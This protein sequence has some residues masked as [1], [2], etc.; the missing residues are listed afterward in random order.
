MKEITEAKEDVLILK[1]PNENND[2]NK[3]DNQI[4][5][6]YKFLIILSFQF[7]LIMNCISLYW[8]YQ[9]HYFFGFYF[10]INSNT[11]FPIQLS[12]FFLYLLCICISGII[13][14]S[15]FHFM[16]SL[17]IATMKCEDYNIFNQIISKYSFLPISFNSLIY[18]IGRLYYEDKSNSTLY[19]FTLFFIDLI[20]LFFLFEIIM[21]KKSKRLK[22]YRL[23]E[24]N[25]DNLYI[26][27]VIYN[28]YFFE[29]LL[30]LNYYFC[31]YVM[32]QITFFLAKEYKIENYIGIIS[33][34]FLGISSLYINWILKSEC[35]SL[36]FEII[37]SGILHSKITLIKEV[38]NELH[39]GNEEIILSIIFLILFSFELVYIIVFN[40]QNRN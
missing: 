37:F 3:N 27:N 21:N 10:P 16:K 15:Y 32:C 19:N 12:S 33:Q 25:N 13:T 29:T 11:Y 40:S 36:F 1:V 28:K 23:N 2:I 39:L 30:S 35:F 20:S 38:K 4:N 9:H 34:L 22:Y 18:Y 31:F 6:I 5:C 24:I 8:L 7:L 26:F 14:I 17:F